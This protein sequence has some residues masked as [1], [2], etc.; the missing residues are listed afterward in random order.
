[1]YEGQLEAWILTLVSEG[2]VAALLARTFG[3]TPWKAAAAAVAGSLVSHPIVWWSYHEL[4]IGKLG[5][6]PTFAIVEAFAV[7]V[8]APFYRLAGAPRWSAAFA[9]SFV[10]NAASVLAGFAMYAIQGAL[11]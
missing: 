1:M 9:I 8:E 7:S 6:W 5:Y 3:M 4:F 2:I 10:V 11:R